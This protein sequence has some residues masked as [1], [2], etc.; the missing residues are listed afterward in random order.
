MINWLDLWGCGHTTKLRYPTVRGPF[1]NS[2]HVREIMGC[3]PKFSLQCIILKHIKQ[4]STCVYCIFIAFYKADVKAGSHDKLPLW[5]VCCRNRGGP[6]FHSQQQELQDNSKKR[7]LIYY[8][9][10]HVI[11]SMKIIPRTPE[12][13]TSRRC[14]TP[15]LICWNSG[16]VTEY[17]N[18][19]QADITNVFETIQSL[20]LISAC[21][22]CVVSNEPLA[23]VSFIVY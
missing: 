9:N 7:V 16:P 19:K 13:D 6:C 5:L 12:E 17:G 3:S 8:N 18:I 1:N 20:Q 4:Q 21:T 11:S 15:T 2:S 22:V 14:P 10:A 23:H